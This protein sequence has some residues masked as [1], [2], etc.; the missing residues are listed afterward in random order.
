MLSAMKTLFA[1]AMLVTI[2]PTQDALAQGVSSPKKTFSLFA[3]PKAIHP[4]NWVTTQ[5]RE[6][7][8]STGEGVAYF[9]LTVSPAGDIEQCRI[10]ESSGF[11]ILD[12]LTCS[13][14]SHRGHFRP[15][16][17]ETG[18]PVA[19]T[20]INRVRW[21]RPGHTWEVPPRR[22]D[23]LLT[24]TKL[25]EHVASPVNVRVLP[26]VGPEGHVEACE[27]SIYDRAPDV[28]KVIACKQLGAELPD[29]IS[30]D[31]SGGGRRMMRSLVVEFSTDAAVNTNRAN[32]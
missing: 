22:A 2:L 29:L 30:R 31:Q 9:E 4:E 32:P 10:I 19:S 5:D 7:S 20:W 15:A 24:V 3:E 16:L 25:P 1:I 6:R 17:D 27:G 8:G 12:R 23:V 13:L 18:Q 14:I 11:D 26:I 28:L 21:A